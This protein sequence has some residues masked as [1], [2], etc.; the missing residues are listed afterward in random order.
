MRKLVVLLAVVLG[1][2]ATALPAGAITGNYVED[3]EH[4][5]V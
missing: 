2:L 1:M 5:F 3:Y 4:P